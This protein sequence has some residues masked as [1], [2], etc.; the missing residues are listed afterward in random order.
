MCLFPAF[1]PPY[2]CVNPGCPDGQGCEHPDRTRDVCGGPE[3]C[4][5]N[6]DC[7]PGLYCELVLGECGGRGVCFARPQ[8]CDAE[9]EPVCGCDGRSYSNDCERRSVGVPFAGAGE[10]PAGCVAEGDTIAVIPDPPQ[11][12]PGLR[13]IGCTYPDPDGG[14]CLPGRRGC[15]NVCAHCGDD[16]CGLGE[17]VCNCP[18]DC[19][20]G[21]E[22]VGDRECAD[23]VLCPAIGG[24]DMDQCTVDACVQGRCEIALSPACTECNDECVP[25]DSE[26]PPSCECADFGEDLGRL[27]TFDAVEFCVPA[28]GQ[29]EAEAQ[30]LLPELRCMGSA[31]RIGCTPPREKVCVFEPRHVERAG[32]LLCND[33]RRICLVSRLSGIDAIRGTFFE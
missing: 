13:A 11:C 8:G 10:C 32:P 9:Y 5:S 14:E 21:P 28:D 6:A 17:N 18:Q 16:A 19:V 29:L 4:A 23:D 20:A 22:C 2:C 30:R 7:G 3:Q 25:D 27:G 31:G 26:P 15:G 12:C 1:N 33:W 24:C